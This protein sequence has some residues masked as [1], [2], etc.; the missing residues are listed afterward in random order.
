[1]CG[2]LLLLLPRGKHLHCQRLGCGE[3]S[4][5][6]AR[7]LGQPP[8]PISFVEGQEGV[9]GFT[10]MSLG[11]SGPKGCVDEI[12]KK[13]LFAAQEPYPLSLSQTIAFTSLSLS[14]PSSHTEKDSFFR[15]S[16]SK[17]LSLSL[18]RERMSCLVEAP[19]S[20][21]SS[22]STRCS[23]RYGCC[24]DFSAHPPPASQ[25]GSIK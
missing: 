16:P 1:M 12:L 13:V 10:L 19:T 25:K 6:R 4:S 24:G 17:V 11:L 7:T 5:E 9:G 3:G 14:H 15:P 18:P 23:T 8:P 2:G 20:S 22:P 21:S